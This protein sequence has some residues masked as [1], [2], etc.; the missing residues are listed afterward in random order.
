MQ[1]PS[2]IDPRQ[3][4]PVGLLA[5]PARYARRVTRRRTARDSRTAVM[6]AL[7]CVR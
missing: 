4:P 1:I 5:H 6:A 3:P 2:T 7:R